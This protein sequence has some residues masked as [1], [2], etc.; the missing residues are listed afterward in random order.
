VNL[1]EW[2]SYL[3]QR[4]TRE[5][6]LT[7]D[8]SVQDLLEELRGY[9]AP[10]RS[11]STSSLVAHADSRVFVPLELETDAGVLSFISTTTVFGTPVDVTIAE[12]ALE[13]FFPANAE[14]AEFLRASLL[15]SSSRED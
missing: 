15:P 9:P 13:S 6:E 3:L 12:L 2:R 11:T 5:S 4:L 14:T 10:T 1:S 7:G 8:S